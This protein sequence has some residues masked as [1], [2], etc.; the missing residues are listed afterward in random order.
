MRPLGFALFGRHTLRRSSSSEHRS[1]RPMQNGGT[2]RRDELF[3]RH[4]AIRHKPVRVHAQ[5][6]ARRPVE[7]ES[8]PLG[9]L[10][11]TEVRGDRIH[12]SHARPFDKSRVTPVEEHREM[13]EMIPERLFDAP[14]DPH[15]P[16]APS[17]AERAENFRKKHV[18]DPFGYL[19][20]ASVAHVVDV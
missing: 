3:E 12:R 2:G 20:L 14:C 5:E 10:L 11:D 19:G 4:A 13:I 1:R 8:L 6:H 7:D 16:S 9:H 17:Q 15:T 18:F